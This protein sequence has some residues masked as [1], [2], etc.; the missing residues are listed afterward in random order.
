MS[1][2]RMKGGNK[3]RYCE[4]CRLNVYNLAEMSDR[5]VD[6]IVRKSTGRLCGL[7]YMRGDRTATLQDCP[8]GSIRRKF[9][10]MMA[11]GGVLLLA[12]LGWLLRIAG[13]RDRS[14]H[15]RWARAVIEWLDPRPSVKVAGM[16]IPPPP[17]PPPPP[18]AK[19]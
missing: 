12:S 7:L 9:R 18:A 5:E 10:R 17:P 16:I 11:V 6:A 4:Q 3:I 19:Q 8:R 1:W 13:E 15:P 2:D 14:V